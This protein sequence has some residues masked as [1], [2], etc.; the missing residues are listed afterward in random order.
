[1]GNGRATKATALFSFCLHIFY[2]GP[3]HSIIYARSGRYLT[4]FGDK[5]SW[6]GG[7]VVGSECSFVALA[8]FLEPRGGMTILFEYF[9]PDKRASRWGL[10]GESCRLSV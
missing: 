5:Q 1:M 10:T 6:G 4:Q 2:T 7:R 3:I 9:I 8:F